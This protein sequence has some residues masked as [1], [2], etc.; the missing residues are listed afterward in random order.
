MKTCLVLTPTKSKFSPLFYAGN[1]EYGI[2][3]ASEIGYDGIEI[4]IRDSS[5]INQEKIIE[6]SDS[7]NLDIVSIGTGQAYCEEGLSLA[8]A[9][10]KIREQTFKRLKDHIDFANKIGAQVVLGSIR[11]KYSIDEKTRK[12]EKIGAFETI[13]KCAKYAMGQGVI[14][15]LEPINKRDTNFINTIDETLG[16]IEDL[17]CEN[18]KIVADTYQME[19]EEKSIEDSLK[20]A[21]NSI[22][23]VHLVDTDRKIPGLGNIDFKTILE[24]L[25]KIRYNGFL[26]AEIIPIPDDDSAAQLYLEKVKKLLHDNIGE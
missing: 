5:K 18:V 23:H 21:G 26:S 6:L 10:K 16:Y 8:N 1:L 20:K 22:V 2:K 7:Y 25:K 19:T 11:G 14:L 15:T 9:D 4:N 12:N 3:R 24:T 17:D 13:K